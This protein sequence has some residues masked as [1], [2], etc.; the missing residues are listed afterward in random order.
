MDDY[1]EIQN[2]VSLQKELAKRK[3]IEDLAGGISDKFDSI[4]GLAEQSNPK[5]AGMLKEAGRLASEKNV[6][7]KSVLRDILEGAMRRKNMLKSVPVLGGLAGTAAALGSGDVGAATIDAL[8]P[9]GVEGLGPEKG[10][11][12]YNI[13][14]PERKPFPKT[15]G[16]LEETS[17]QDELKKQYL[18]NLAMK[19]MMR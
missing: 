6:P 12:D 4:I 19:G 8:V 5:M 14:N 9:G 18:K 17:M 11:L 16:N 13:E 2:I 3:Q 1:N 15:S 10:S 7:T